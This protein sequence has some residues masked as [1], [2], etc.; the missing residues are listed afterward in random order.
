MATDCHVNLDAELQ[1]MNCAVNRGK[2]RPETALHVSCAIC[3]HNM[4]P[5]RIDLPFVADLFELVVD[6][7][8]CNSKNYFPNFS[9]LI[10]CKKNFNFMYTGLEKARSLWIQ[11]S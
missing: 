11:F 5:A 4:T 10:S 1:T 9:T 3:D 2:R 8:S 6:V 7:G